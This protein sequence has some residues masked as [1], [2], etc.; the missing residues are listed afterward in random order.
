MANLEICILKA[1]SL[2]ELKIV[3]TSSLIGLIIAVS[4]ILALV[5]CGGET[6]QFFFRFFPKFQE[7]SPILP[8]AGWDSPILVETPSPPSVILVSL[9]FESL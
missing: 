1:A 5:R 9:W 2:G 7:F 8:K 6:S 4:L 3:T